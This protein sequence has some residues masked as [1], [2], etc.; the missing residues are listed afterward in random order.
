MKTARRKI[1][2]PR[3]QRSSL[4]R[5][6]TPKV[7]DLAQRCQMHVNQIMSGGSGVRYR[8]WSGR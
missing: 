5:C 3:M 7:T 6:E 4:R 1:D 8:Q 2:A